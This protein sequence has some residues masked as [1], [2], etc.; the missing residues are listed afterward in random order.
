MKTT[1]RFFFGVVAALTT[2]VAAHAASPAGTWSFN[3][4]GYTSSLMLTVDAAGNV[5]GTVFGNQIVGFWNDSAAKLTFY[6]VTGGSLISVQPDKIQVYTG[7]MH[8]C[9]V[10]DASGGQCLEGSFEA[11][12]G[13]GGTAS[14]SVYGW[15]AYKP[16]PPYN[17]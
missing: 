7:Y 8:A 3:S 15:S 13:T 16:N 11:I 1:R 17:P 4:N 14:K 5:H 2:V 6:R 10:S 9:L 12:A